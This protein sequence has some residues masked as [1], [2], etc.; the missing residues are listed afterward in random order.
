MTE[1][2]L[3]AAGLTKRY[4]QV[5]ALQAADFPANPGAVAYASKVIF[6][7]E[8]TAALGVVQR[9][10]VL[11]TIRRVRDRGVSV[12]L[13]SHNM[14]EVLAVSDRVE[15]LRLG[16]RVARYVTAQTS[17]EELVGAMTGALA[18]E[19]AA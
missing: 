17:V 10:R 16:R 2:L 3:R 14:P 7:D 9:G 5:H 6:M 13:I 18:G 19:A 1:P 8:P 4:G 11:D 12:V 15:V